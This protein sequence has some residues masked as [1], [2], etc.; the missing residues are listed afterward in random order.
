MIAEGGAGARAKCA[1]VRLEATRTLVKSPPELWEL[2]DDESQLRQWSSQLCESEQVEVTERDRGRL[3]A[4]RCEGSHPTLI[5]V[6]LSE[7]GF[8][9]RVFIR[10]IAD[11]G[12]RAEALDAVLDEL[13][14]PQRRPFSAT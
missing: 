14:E 5:E 1:S 4:W 13:A 6:A 11:G 2:L 10:A 7:K 9:T 8:G 3:L 12:L